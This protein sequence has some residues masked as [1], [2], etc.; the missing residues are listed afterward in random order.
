MYH[1]LL[2]VALV[3][4][5][6][7][8]VYGLSLGVRRRWRRLDSA[9]IDP[10]SSTLSY[11]A[12]TY[13]VLV[14]F[15]ILLLFGQ[16]ADARA[17][18][19]DEATSIGTAF[20]Q[21]RLFPDSTQGIQQ[22]LICYGE[23]AAAYDW[24]AMREGTSAPEVDRA[25]SAL[26]QS[27]GADDQPPTGA[28]HSA[29]ATNLASQI[30]AISTARESRLVAAQAGLPTMMW[31]LLFGGGVLVAFLLFMVTLTARPATQA[32]LVAIAAAFTMTMLLLVGALST[33]FVDAPGR[34]SPQLIDETVATMQQS[35]PGTDS[36]PCPPPPAASG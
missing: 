2:N 9:T 8:V 5:V 23:T 13:G 1:P 22:A 24:P 6:G 16:F 26:V 20:E 11:V 17:A 12:T 35:L 21:A 27:L 29:T 34:V 31:V 36:V 4:L 10:W 30:G 33:P 14:G 3:L 19:G 7:A 25:F 18:V 15:S 32:G 28:L